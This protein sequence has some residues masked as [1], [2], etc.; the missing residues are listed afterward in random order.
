M[1]FPAYIFHSDKA[2]KARL[3]LDACN[4]TEPCF[5]FNGQY[6]GLMFLDAG[7]AERDPRWIPLFQPLIADPLN[8]VQLVN[9]TLEEITPTSLQQLQIKL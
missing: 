2:L 4:F 5:I 9:L 8:E 6:K 1:S 7:L 3:S